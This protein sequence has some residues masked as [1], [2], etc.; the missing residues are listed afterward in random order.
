MTIG[1]NIPS[2]KANKLSARD[3]VTASS[4]SAP[5]SAAKVRI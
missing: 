5:A 3:I 1:S 2:D 4:S